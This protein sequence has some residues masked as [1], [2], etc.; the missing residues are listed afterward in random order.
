MITDIVEGIADKSESALRHI[1]KAQA[2]LRILVAVPVI[3]VET[4]LYLGSPA[5]VAARLV[6]LS[7]LY[8]VYILALRVLVH[9]PQIVS[10][11]ALLVA[12]AVLDPLALTAW[13][14]VTGEYGGLIVGFYLFTILGFG[15]RTGRPLMYLCQLTAVA[16]F[17]LVCL[18]VPYWQ[19]HLTTFLALLIPL[20]VVPMYAGMLIK[21]L[22]ESRELAERESKA[23]SELLA[24]VS[25]EL[26][27][28]L[29]GI[30][31]ATELMAGEATQEVVRRR[32]DTILSLS[33]KLLREINDLLDEA[34]LDAGATRLE[35]APVDIKAQVDLVHAA[36]AELAVKKG[37]DF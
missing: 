7:I 10:S 24:K 19:E 12:T 18:G 13:L 31:S 21:S 26:R 2:T 4:I 15:F 37:I 17:L 35:L 1:L 23:K 29:A 30:I 9:F 16:G 14:V 25:H 8:C 3:I 33:G 6:V 28:P 11:R 36:L 27:T 20:L 22:R 34:K 5:S 32:A